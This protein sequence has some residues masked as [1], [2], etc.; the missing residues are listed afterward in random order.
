L[1]RVI[2]E[3]NVDGVGVD[4]WHLNGPKAMAIAGMPSIALANSAGRRSVED[5]QGL[6]H[7][8][9]DMLSPEVRLSRSRTHHLDLHASVLGSSPGVELSATGCASPLPSMKTRFVSVPWD[10]R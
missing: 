3:K 9:T 5:L 1:R 10:T 8:R 6:Q 2:D 4:G 7:P